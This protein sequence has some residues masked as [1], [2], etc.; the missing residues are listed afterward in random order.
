[1]ATVEVTPTGEATAVLFPPSQASR[2]ARRTRTEEEA[3]ERKV[4]SSDASVESCSTAGSE[5]DLGAKPLAIPLRGMVQHYAWGKAEDESL[6]AAIA[7]G[8]DD[9]RMPPGDGARKFAELWMGTHQNGHS[10]VLTPMGAPVAGTWRLEAKLLKDTISSDPEHWLGNDWSRGDLPYLLKVL[11]VRQA[12]SIQA[13]PNKKLAERLHRERPQ[14]Y[15]D[16]NHKPEICIPL[17]HFEAL[18]GFRPIAEVQGFVRSVEELRQLCSRDPADEPESLGLRELFSRLMRSDAALAEQQVT[19]LVARLSAKSSAEQS[20]EEDLILRLVKEYPGDVGIFAVYFLNQVCITADVPR[21]YIYCAADEPHAYLCGD[22]VECMAISDNVV[23][24]GLTSKHKDVD[25]LLEMMT[26]RDD[27]L[28]ELVGFGEQVAP[29]VVKYDPPVEDFVVYEIDGPVVE[30]LYLPHAAI[31]LCVG[32]SFH[33]DF[34][35][36]G[37]PEDDNGWVGPAQDSTGPQAIGMGQTFFSRAGSELVVLGKPGG[38]KI[39]VATY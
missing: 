10:S 23:R 37:S 13:H 15:P 18:V 25:K 9:Q 20:R 6:V 5:R 3:D 31:T 24:A 8:Q 4:S 12:L 27:L 34:Q 2:K 14:H 32:G 29:H 21:Q 11:S 16:A 28:G 17:G 7:R 33:V 1:M 22:A 26:Y 30:G 19:A 39:F 38:G 36:V 35:H